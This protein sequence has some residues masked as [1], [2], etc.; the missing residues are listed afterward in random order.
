MAERTAVLFLTHRWNG[1]MFLKFE[2]LRLE[3]GDRADVFLALQESGEALAA[4]ERFPVAEERCMPFDANGLAAELG[5]RLFAEDRLVPGSTH[6]PVLAFAR[7][8][9]AYDRFVLIEFDVDFTGA[10]GELLDALAASPCDFV[11]LHL[12][13]HASDPGFYFWP[14]MEPA[15]ADREWAADPANLWRS[16]NPIYMIT[17][18]AL[19]PVE[20]AHRRGWHAHYEILLATILMREG[21]AIGSLGEFCIG[22]EQDPLPGVPV[23]QLATVRWRPE[24]T[25]EEIRERSTGRTLFHPVKGPWCFDGSRIVTVKLADAGES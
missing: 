12:R 1:L 25:R 7:R 8:M 16:F 9:P 22:D 10:W 3:V 13:S 6:Y 4:L 20:A 24:V 17:R 23:E 21:R 18:E 14:T 2:R 19:G 5:Y 15:A 11:P